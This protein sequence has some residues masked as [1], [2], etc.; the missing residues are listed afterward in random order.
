MAIPSAQAQAQ[1]Q[2]S[3][4]DLPGSIGVAVDDVIFSSEQD[5]APKYTNTSQTTGAGILLVAKICDALSKWGGY[6]DDDVRGVGDLVAKNLITYNSSHVKIQSGTSVDEDSDSKGSGRDVPQK[7]VA[8]MLK[9]LVDPTVSRSRNVH[10]NSNEPVL[11]V[12]FDYPLLPN[13]TDWVNDVID[14]TV[15][16]LQHQWNIWP[17][18]VYGYASPS[19][20]IKPMATDASTSHEDVQ[21]NGFSITL[22]NVVNTNIG[23][24]S[25]PQLLDAPCDAPEW[26]RYVR[27]EI[28]REQHLVSREVGKEIWSP[29]G[30]SPAHDDNASEQSF[31]SGSDTE[32]DKSVGSDAANLA[33]ESNPEPAEAPEWDNEAAPE[34]EDVAR[35]AAAHG[36]T[37]TLAHSEE[38]LVES[39]IDE[40]DTR[41]ATQAPNQEELLSKGFEAPERQVRHPTW[42]RHGDST[43]LID[44]IRS[45]ASLIAPFGTEDA[46]Q[47]IGDIEG[48]GPNSRT[49]DVG[50]PSA[51][52][53]EY[54]VVGDSSQ[55]SQA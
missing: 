36:E 55:Q 9:A 22:L 7:T 25:M 6:G 31:E 51:D 15:Q 28:W 23:G 33:T 48:E 43:S 16:E 11:L 2:G 1:A 40:D 27:Q 4:L 8:S 18:R 47:G 50:S 10:V 17:V 13:D 12:N 30:D 35:E 54:I 3:M 37:Q 34:H 21:C 49:E 14:A 20:Y 29:Q 19:T 5:S 42:E 53:D 52:E 26:K 24:P 46:G 45:Q 44:L 41:D 39:G 38:D 32:D